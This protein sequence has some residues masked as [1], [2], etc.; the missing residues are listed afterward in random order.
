MNSRT[1]VSKQQELTLKATNGPET[2]VCN[3]H[4]TDRTTILVPVTTVLPWI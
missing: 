1:Q 4:P 3:S 2:W